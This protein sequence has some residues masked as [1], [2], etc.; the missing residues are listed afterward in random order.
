[1]STDNSDYKTKWVGIPNQTDDQLKQIAKD[2]F[3]G[4][5]FCDRQCNGDVM[6]VFM[7]MLFMGPQP[8][9]KPTAPENN[10]VVENREEISD[11]FEKEEELLKEYKKQKK[12]YKKAY[13]YYLENYIPSIGFVY[14]YLTEAGPMSINGKPNFFSTRFLNKEDTTKMF[15]YYETYKEKRESVDNF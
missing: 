10:D 3:N 7:V 15:E 13:K 5:I 6:S 4:L 2:L 8:P 11:Y 1:M 14:E 9:T 12:L